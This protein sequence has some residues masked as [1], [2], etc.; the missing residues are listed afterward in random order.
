MGLPTGR[1]EHTLL[2]SGIETVSNVKVFAKSISGLVCAA[3]APS[4][5]ENMKLL[6]HSL[7]RTA[8]D[9]LLTRVGP[10]SVPQG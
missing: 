10:L 2:L 4:L 1:R 3:D 9:S 8:H 5:S 6:Q 7:A